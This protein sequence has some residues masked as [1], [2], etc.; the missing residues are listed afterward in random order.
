MFSQLM[1]WNRE[2][3]GIAEYERRYAEA[4]VHLRFVCE[5]YAAQ[6]KEGG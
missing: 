5:L 6:I 1:N 2:K 4:M 3:M